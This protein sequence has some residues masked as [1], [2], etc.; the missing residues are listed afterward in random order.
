MNWTTSKFK[1]S[2]HKRHNQ[3]RKMA[4]WK[5]VLANH[6]SDKGLIFRI[7]TAKTEQ[8]QKKPKQNGERI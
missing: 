7:K 1:T 4:T 3:H 6:I 5:K 8:Q 2:V